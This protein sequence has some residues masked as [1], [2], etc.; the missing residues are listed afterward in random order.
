MIISRRR[1]ARS[2]AADLRGGA[3]IHGIAP[4]LAA[5]MV[6]QRLTGQFDEI[7]RDIAYE[8]ARLGRL[9]ATVTTARPLSDDLRELV[10]DYLRGHDKQADIV[11]NETVDE[12]I[13]GGIIIETP[14]HQLDASVRS[15]LKQLKTT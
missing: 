14:S 8:L 10:R 7:V 1:I 2:I 5:Y 6:E 4:R 13:I 3:D 15:T 11:L 12:S 9:E